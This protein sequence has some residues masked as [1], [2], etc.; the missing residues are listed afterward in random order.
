MEWRVL[1]N[2]RM[3]WDHRNWRRPYPQCHHWKLRPYSRGSL[4]DKDYTYSFNKALFPR[5]GLGVWRIIPWL[6][7]VIILSVSSL[8]P[9]RTGP[10][11]WFFTG[12]VPMGFLWK[13]HHPVLTSSSNVPTST[14]NSGERHVS[15]RASWRWP[16]R[17]V[18]HWFQPPNLLDGGGAMFCETQ[19]W[20]RSSLKEMKSSRNET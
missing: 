6:G 20:P 1:R 18:L 15:A 2:V 5:K 19:P 8:S 3:F 17:K 14:R 4:R 10:P 11:G 9:R 12:F 13:K 7:Y 16:C